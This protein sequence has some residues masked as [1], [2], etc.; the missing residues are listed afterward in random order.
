MDAETWATLYLPAPLLSTPECCL[1]TA[2]CSHCS[3]CS[4][5]HVLLL[6]W[7]AEHL[8]KWNPALLQKGI[9]RVLKHFCYKQSRWPD[10]ALVITMKQP[11]L[12]LFAVTTSVAPLLAGLQDV[13]LE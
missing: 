5:P 11:L 10:K 2:G 4:V 6:L 8:T 7:K 13:H 12:L 1:K 3:P 9:F